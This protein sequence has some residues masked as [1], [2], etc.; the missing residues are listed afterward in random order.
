MFRFNGDGNLSQNLNLSFSDFKQK[1][2]YN[3][4]RNG[5]FEKLA[6]F[7]QTLKKY[8]TSNVYIVGSFVTNKE[9]PRDIDICWDT[10]GIDY[11]NCKNEHPEFFTDDGVRKFRSVTGIHIA[12]MFNSYSTDMLEWFQFDKQKNFRGCVKISLFNIDTA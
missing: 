10:T 6:V 5:L 9:K 8:G 12:A 4:Q 7:L 1:F 2:S 11:K 3:E